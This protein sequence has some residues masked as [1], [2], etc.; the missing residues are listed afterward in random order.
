[1]VLVVCMKDSGFGM[2]SF[3]QKTLFINLEGSLE[4]A[5]F[6]LCVISPFHSTYR[7]DKILVKHF[8]FLA[9]VVI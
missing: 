1:M 7:V 2:E 4:Q 8:Y 9:F 6:S 5:L 3:K